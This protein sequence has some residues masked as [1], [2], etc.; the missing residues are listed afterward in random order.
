MFADI[1]CTSLAFDKFRRAMRSHTAKRVASSTLYKAILPL[2]LLL[3]ASSSAQVPTRENWIA[4]G[5]VAH[6]N[7]PIP[8]TPESVK[9][10]LR[11]F[12]NNC[13]SCHGAAGKG[14]GQLAAFLPIKPANLNNADVWKQTDGTIFWKVSTG[15]Q[16]MPT[17]GPILKEEERWN[18]INYL[19]SSFGPK[20]VAAE[21]TPIV[22]SNAPARA[23]PVMAVPATAPGDPVPAARE[24]YEALVRKL[25]REHREMQDE[26]QELRI[27][28]GQANSS[29][30]RAEAPQPAPPMPASAPAAA[31][32]EAV[33]DLQTQ[34]DALKKDLKHALP[35]TEGFFIAGDAFVGFSA[36]RRNNSTFS[37]GMAP[38]LL[39]KPTSKLFFESSFDL[40]LN[41]DP[42]TTSSTSIN[43]TIADVAILVNDWLTVGGGVFVTP[44]GV[45]HNHFDPPW[46]NKFVDDP[47]PFADGGIA[48]GSSL[49]LFARGA[50]LIGNSKIVYDAYVINGPNL[51]TA[52]KTAAGSLAF[53][54]WSDLNNDKAVGGRLGFIPIPN[55]ELG[56]SVMAGSVQPSGFRSTHALL[57]AVDLNF[58]PDVEALAGTFDF[59]TEWVWSNVE[60]ATYDPTRRLGFGPLNFS[61]Y[62]NGGYVQLCY[63]PTHVTNEFIRSFELCA[64]W[65]FL[66]TPV[67]APGGGTEQRYTIGVDYWLN[68][69]AVLKLDYEFDRR[70]S[71]LGP[72]QNALLFQLGLGL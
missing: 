72:A 38:L 5:N 54:N 8:V 29:G 43:L 9:A 34:L 46:I 47:L 2:L 56:Y 51:I 69:Q 19:R 48:P 31:G 30:P 26:I 63:R 58:R 6:R 70:S 35:G 33:D 39:W 71:S 44:F 1:A 22:A 60:R 64:R 27:E 52:D 13:V 57:Q 10:G 17:W 4:P 67:A 45:Y 20:T 62:R 3:V 28:R 42:D 14:D 37:A 50:Q 7:N 65:D 25:L 15:R 40:G 66:R 12:S 24:D 68:P 55:M 21:P 53:N 49:G 36:Q 11:I 23:V 16:P 59:R 61:N 18:V 41:T 32:Q